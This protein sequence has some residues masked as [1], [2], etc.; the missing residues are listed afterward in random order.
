MLCKPNEIIHFDNY[1][2]S[3]NLSSFRIA[4]VNRLVIPDLP[5]NDHNS[6]ESIYN[7]LVL[8]PNIR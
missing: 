2:H 5:L 4:F 6:D 8:C 1:I 3:T 7:F